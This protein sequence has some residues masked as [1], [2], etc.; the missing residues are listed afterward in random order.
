MTQ[1]IPAGNFTPATLSADDLYITIQNPPGFITGVP[2]DVIGVVGTADWGPVNMPVLMGSPNAALTTFGG[3]SARSLTDP[4]D[5]ATDLAI[6]FGQ[7]ASQSTLQAWGVR[8]TDGTDTAATAA[9]PGAASSTGETVVVGG[10]AHVG[11]VLNLTVTSS[12][13]TGSPITVTHTMT[14]TDT[15]ATAAVALAAAVNANS[16]LAAAGIVALAVSSGEF[17]VYQ[18]TAL[19]PQAT[20]GESVTGGGATTTLTLGSGSA[21][22]TGMTLSAVYTGFLGNGLQITVQAGAQTNSFTALLALPAI[23]AQESFPNIAG[24]TKFWANLVSAINNGISGVRGP[25]QIARASAPNG[26]VGAPTLATTTASGGT[27]GRSG[28]VTATLI[29]S[30]ASIPTTGLYALTALN[31]AVGVVWLVGCT[32]PNANASLL[33]FEQGN[34]ATALVPF[35][36]GTTTAAALTLVASQAIHDPGFAYVKDWIYWFDPVNGVVRLSPPTA[37]IG[38]LIATLPPQV[39]PGNEP[40]NMVLGTERV[41]PTGTVPYTQS[42][43]GQ[44]ASAGIMFVYNPIPAGTQFG[45]RV[46]QTTSLNAATAGVEWWRTS[47]FLARSFATTMGQFVDGLQSQQPNDPL[48]NAVKNQLNTFLQSLVGNNGTVGVIDSY[49][50]ICSFS[51]SPSATPGNGVNTPASIAQHYLYVLVRVTYLS[52]VRFFVLALQG[53][54]TVVTIGATPGQQIAA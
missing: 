41:A 50:V 35:P 19:S 26:A 27:S 32:D 42:E 18:P 48:R 20:F 17:E 53:G 28:V 34:G 15:L 36:T 12:A 30:N 44:C 46:G 22:S 6:A 24:G 45:I 49:S 23:G 43:I 47:V 54:T 5:M 7:A 8:V 51:A 2:T 37:F 39:N 1:I 9:V 21:A 3:I 14:G 13:L 25:S 16:V 33:S 31:P 52:T 40:V 4:Y 10:T 38:G 29:G 11:D